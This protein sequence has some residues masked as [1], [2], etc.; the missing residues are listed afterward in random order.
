MPLPAIIN[1]AHVRYPYV[2]AITYIAQTG[3]EL[4][5]LKL[6]DPGIELENGRVTLVGQLIVTSD[7]QMFIYTNEGIP[8]RQDN[9][10]F[11][12]LVGE[13]AFTAAQ[14]ALAKLKEEIPGI[15][16]TVGDFMGLPS[17]QES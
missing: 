8:L 6:I 3:E 14:N 2:T 11:R 1:F 10:L 12:L 16:Y 4:F 5:E 13:D 9:E 15:E 7:R 17:T